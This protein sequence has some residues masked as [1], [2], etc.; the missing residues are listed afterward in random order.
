[1]VLGK[2]RRV[3]IALYIRQKGSGYRPS[4]W[5]FCGKFQ[6]GLRKIPVGFHHIPPEALIM[7]RFGGIFA[8]P[9]SKNK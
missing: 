9:E 4:F 2:W 3:G 8:R 7:H 1:M 5:L 6:Y